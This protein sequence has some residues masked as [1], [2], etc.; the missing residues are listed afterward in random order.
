MQKT[1]THVGQFSGIN[2]LGTV[3]LDGW[4]LDR[5]AVFTQ[6][7]VLAEYGQTLDGFTLAGMGFPRIGNSD[8]FAYYA[9]LVETD[10]DAIVSPDRILIKVGDVVEGMNVGGI[11]SIGPLT[12]TGEVPITMSLG[13]FP[14]WRHYVATQNRV[15]FRAGDI[16]DGLSVSG[17]RG[18]NTVLNDRG[19]LALLGAIQTDEGSF[20]DVL[21]AGGKRIIAEGDVFDAHIVTEIFPNFDMN[22]RGDIAFR[23]EFEDG[24]RAVIAASV[25][26]PQ[27]IVMVAL[28]LV[29]MAGYR[30]YQRVGKGP[31]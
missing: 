9:L 25:P 23:V 20:Y 2:D 3:I 29:T 16:I 1:I 27:N 21:F 13:D 30:L 24:S 6:T 10:R 31:P 19:D 18:T 22:D 15:L 7:R 12:F 28:V 26:E 14:D 17:L 5:P 4:I 11:H 8:D